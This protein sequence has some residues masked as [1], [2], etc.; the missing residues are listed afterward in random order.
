[1]RTRSCT[2]KEADKDL[3]YGFV[4]TVMAILQRAGVDNLGMVTDPTP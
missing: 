4:V 3:P 1:M 2:L